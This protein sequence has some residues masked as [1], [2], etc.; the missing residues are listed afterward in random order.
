MPTT[1]C[2]LMYLNGR[3]FAVNGRI[4]Q[5]LTQSR[6]GIPVQQSPDRILR[7]GFEQTPC[8]ILTVNTSFT[9]QGFYEECNSFTNTSL[10][11]LSLVDKLGIYCLR[12]SGTKAY[13]SAHASHFYKFKLMYDPTPSNSP[14][15]SR[16]K[17]AQKHP[18]KPRER[19]YRLAVFH[20]NPIM[21]QHISTHLALPYLFHGRR[22]HPC[23]ISAFRCSASRWLR[24][25]RL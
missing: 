19:K 4:L 25:L 5:S 12:V 3:V 15:L 13:Q 22:V 6:S 7:R 23:S 17:H 8:K 21:A 2:N 20:L 9:A 16:T 14:T 18:N 10:D 24:L 11:I 1:T